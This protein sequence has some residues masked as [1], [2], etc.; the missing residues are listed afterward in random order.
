[1]TK[2]NHPNNFYSKAFSF[3]LKNDLEAKVKSIYPKNEQQWKEVFNN[4]LTISPEGI[5]LITQYSQRLRKGLL[6]NNTFSLYCNNVRLCERTSATFFIVYFNK[7]DEIALGWCSNNTKK[8]LVSDYFKHWYKHM[9]LEEEDINFP[10]IEYS[11]IKTI[12]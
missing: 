4:I 9:V 8:Q 10:C 6:Y 3:T 11:F 5:T 7:K 2:A 1:M 12:K